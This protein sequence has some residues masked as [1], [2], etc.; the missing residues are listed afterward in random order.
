MSAIIVAELFGLFG[1]FSVLGLLPSLLGFS[2]AGV[3][4][5]S[6]AATVQSSIGNVVAGSAFSAC[7]SV[8]AVG[9]AAALAAAAGLWK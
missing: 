6:V 4:G 9:T 7:Q 5:G 1:I 2:T 8:G 3:V